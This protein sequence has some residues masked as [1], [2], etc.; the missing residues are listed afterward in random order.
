MRRVAPTILIIKMY[1]RWPSGGA[2]G[3]SSL[4]ISCTNLAAAKLSFVISNWHDG[5][6]ALKL[7]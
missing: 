5:Q 1:A 3:E 2:S 6:I 4:T 7:C